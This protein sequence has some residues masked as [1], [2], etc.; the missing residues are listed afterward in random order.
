MSTL[1]EILS[2]RARA[3]IFTILFGLNN[4]NLHLREIERRSSC[5]ID[6]IRRELIKLEKIGLVTSVRNS[7]RLY[8]E[9]N[10]EHPLYNDIHNIVIKTSGVVDVLKS[11][12]ADESVE[13]AF[14]FGS[15]A[16]TQEK[17]N[18]DLDLMIIGDV[19]SREI[20]AKLSS[21]TNSI[22][23]EVNFYIFDR[24]EFIKRQR[25]KDHFLTNLLQSPKIFIIGNQNELDSMG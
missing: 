4:N 6:T 15:I 12:I 11:I 17:A 25:E 10:K 13:I 20:A 21:V 16:A 2:S 8:Y 24:K 3:D 23:R 18:S 14:I 9:A 22:G 1:S 5:T 19:S 7:N